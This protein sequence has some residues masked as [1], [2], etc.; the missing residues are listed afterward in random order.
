MGNLGHLRNMEHILDLSFWCKLIK[1]K[2]NNAYLWI[3]WLQICWRL[4]CINKI[5]QWVQEYYVGAK[6]LNNLSSSLWSTIFHGSAFLLCFT[7]VVLNNSYSG[8]ANLLKIG[9]YQE[10]YPM[11]RKM[12]HD[13]AIDFGRHFTFYWIT[14][15]KLC[16]WYRS[17]RRSSNDFE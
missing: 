16:A 15:T 2:V 10:K 8:F 1:L 14:A 7:V 3:S 11:S 12:P 17:I 4:A 13:S 5:T 6:Q 9:M